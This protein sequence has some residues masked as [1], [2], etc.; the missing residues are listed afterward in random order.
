MS[1]Y[2]VA[3][4][5]NARKESLDICANRLQ[6]FLIVL[7]QCDG[8]FTTWFEKGMSRRNAKQVAIDFS[9][10]DS[11]L[12]ILEKGKYR[13]DDD[14]ESIDDLGFSFGM[15][16]G[17]T[18]ARTAGLTITCGQYAAV[19]GLGGNCVLL[20]LPEELGDLEQ[21]DRMESVLAAVAKC[22]EPDWAGVFSL[23]AMDSREFNTTI[24]FVDWM[25]Y[26]NSKKWHRPQLSQQQIIHQVDN[27]GF[28]VIVQD[29]PPQH[30]A[31]SHL[32]TVRDIK[33][34]IGLD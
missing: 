6:Q 29:S 22:W 33:L 18:S 25:L 3:G 17:E 20:N 16:N 14:K 2:R 11:L 32:Q 10:V 8:V 1:Q 30:D 24:P 9:N 12:H 13:R 4:Y 15:W 5:W 7:A 34:S 21:S 31:V 26:L 28:T 19:S 27:I 23:D